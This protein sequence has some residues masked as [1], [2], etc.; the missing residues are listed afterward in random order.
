MLYAGPGIDTI[1]GGPGTDTIE[2]GESDTVHED[3]SG[4]GE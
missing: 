1:Y 3:D 2:S 4:S